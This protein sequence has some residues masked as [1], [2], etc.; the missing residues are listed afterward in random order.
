MID[1]A[2][3]QNAVNARHDVGV[4]L[5]KDCRSC[6]QLGKHVGKVVGAFRANMTVPTTSEQNG[7]G[8]SNQGENLASEGGQRQLSV[9]GKKDQEGE[10]SGRHVALPASFDRS[11]PDKPLPTRSLQPQRYQGKL[12]GKAESPSQ[13]AE[14]HPGGPKRRKTMDGASLTVTP[15]NSHGIQDSTTEQASEETLYPSEESRLA[16]VD[17]GFEYNC[18]N[19]VETKFAGINSRKVCDAKFTTREALDHHRLHVKHVELQTIL[20]SMVKAG[21]SQPVFIC[22]LCHVITKY[23]DRLK[24]QEHLS[25]Q[26]HYM[27]MCTTGRCTEPFSHYPGIRGHLGTSHGFRSP[28][29]KPLFMWYTMALERSELVENPGVNKT[30]NVVSHMPDNREVGPESQKKG[31]LFN[32]YSLINWEGSE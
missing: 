10:S 25:T 21:G 30:H 26:H 6:G 12:T 2:R 31:E 1:R 28:K 5:A 17:Q 23:Y 11:T 4:C 32:A 29:K 15:A 8:W 7:F 16:L 27:Y 14:D 20:S 22:D 18:D 3:V 13:T 9:R 24:Y 19:V